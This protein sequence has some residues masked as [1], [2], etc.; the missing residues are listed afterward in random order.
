MALR[1]LDLPFYYVK[2]K[3]FEKVKTSAE[4]ILTLDPSNAYGKQALD[5]ANKMLRSKSSTPKTPPPPVK[6]NTPPKPPVTPKDKQ[7][8]KL[9]K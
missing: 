4:G 2:V 7:V 8:S 5:I 6:S 9:K 3:D 1:K